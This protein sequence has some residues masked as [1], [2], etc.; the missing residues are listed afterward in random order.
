MRATNQACSSSTS[1][2][3]SSLRQGGGVGLGGGKGGELGALHQA[4][5]MPHG[6]HAVVL[7]W[8]CGGA[9]EVAQQPR[10]DTGG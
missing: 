4:G 8:Q 9:C 1:A 3:P 2:R 6:V 10:A 7:C 5:R